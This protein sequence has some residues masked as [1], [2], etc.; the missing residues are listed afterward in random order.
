[1]T[2]SPHSPHEQFAKRVL[3]RIADE[4]VTP[5]PR[6][7]FLFK[8]Y[9]FWVLGLFAVLVGALAFS[10]S[11]FEV[12][13]VDWQYSSVTHADLVHF[14]FASAPFFWLAALIVFVVIGYLNVRSTDRG[15]RY[16]LIA[17]GAGAL[18]LVVVLGSSFYAVGFGER[19]EG[20]LGDHPPF[21]RPI[22]VAQRGWWLSP[23]KGLLIGTVEEASTTDTSFTLRDANGHVWQIDTDD[24]FTPDTGVATQGGIVRVVG[25]PADATSSVF[26]ACFVL[27][28]EPNGTHPAAAPSAQRA[29]STPRV[30]AAAPSDTCKNIRPYHTLK[31]LEEAQELGQ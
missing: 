2:T 12:E 6:W 11:L 28:G 10:A 16:S 27:P 15:Y 26:H 23:E 22:S 20:V 19:V 14:F 8:N 7:E 31:T 3:H 29:T 4:R 9:F 18:A 21:Y 25:A 5:R 1:M 13:S 30:A 24:L 17:L